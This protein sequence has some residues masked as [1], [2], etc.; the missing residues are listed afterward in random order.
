MSNN[1]PQLRELLSCDP[2][3]LAPLDA[4]EI[5]IYGAG[6]CGRSVAAAAQRR[7]L[8]VRCFLDE[9]AASLGEIDH[10]PC[11]SPGS[12]AARTA[13]GAEVPAVVAI[14]NYATDPQ[15]VFGL[16]R[17]IGFKRVLSFYEAH[18][19]LGL[20]PQFWLTNR[21]FYRQYGDEILAGF[22]LFEDEIS[23]QIYHDALSL[24][25]T[26]DVGLLREP[27][28]PNQYLAPDLPP[29][30]TPMRLVDGGAFNGDTIRMMMEHGVELEAIAAFEPDPQNFQDLC[31]TAAETIG[32]VRET[33]LFPAGLGEQNAIH[34]FSP[35]GG[36]A[37][38][39]QPHGETQ[40]QVVSLDDVLPT[41]APTFMKFDIEGAE[42]Q[43]LR[44]AARLISRYQPTLAVCVY[45]APEHLWTLPILIRQRWPNYRLALRSHQFNGFDLVAYAIPR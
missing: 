16:L 39:L 9:R 34:P 27:D 15:P 37:S 5:V 44:G 30:R 2:A 10:I 1:R 19:H 20:E 26:F 3:P 14:F 4:R 23:Q 32:H 43:A 21:S 7:G 33:I 35:G 24:R 25:L 40:V 13:A 45:H 8:Q 42:P 11:Y 18:E 41:F 17:A 29:P 22:D 38:S 6:N 36:A 31:R 28:Q 12:E